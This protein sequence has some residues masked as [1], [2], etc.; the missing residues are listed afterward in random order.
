[1]EEEDEGPK[2]WE[3]AKMKKEEEIEKAE[4]D[5]PDDP[6]KSLPGPRYNAMLAVQRNTLYM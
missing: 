2:P 5:D 4:E 3:V 6:E 1:M